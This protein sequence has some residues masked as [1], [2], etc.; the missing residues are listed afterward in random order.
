MVFLNTKK[1]QMNKVEGIVPRGDQ[2][3]Q[4]VGAIIRYRIENVKV[5]LYVFMFLTVLLDRRAVDE[6]LVLKCL[7]HNRFDWRRGC[8]ASSSPKVTT[9]V[10]H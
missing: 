10:A 2:T 7:G 4:Q 6:I 8:E 1:L 3:A 9:N 5:L